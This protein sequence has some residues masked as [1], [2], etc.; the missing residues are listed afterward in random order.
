M[1]LQMVGCSHHNSRLE[2]RERLA[3]SPDE[4]AKALEVLRHRYPEVE[5]VL[6]STCNRVEVYTATQA[7]QPGPTHQ[8]V[9][10][11]LAEFHVIG[12]VRVTTVGSLPLRRNKVYM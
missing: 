12:V 9:V 8:D 11:F 5:A 1:K 6:I 3:F 2:T 10:H 4:S 7:E